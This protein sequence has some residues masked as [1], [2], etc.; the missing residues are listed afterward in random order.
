MDGKT[1]DLQ[2]YKNKGVTLVVT[3]DQVTAPFLIVIND[4]D[5]KKTL[6]YRMY[7]KPKLTLNLPK[8]SSFV[9]LVNDGT[10]KIKDVLIS[11][12]KKIQLKYNFN[13]DLVVPRNYSLNEVKTVYY[14]QIID[15]VNGEPKVLNTPARFIPSLKEKQVS[16]EQMQHFAQ[17]D[18]EFVLDHEEGHYFYGRPYLPDDVIRLLPIS[19]LD[20]SKMSNHFQKQIQEDELEADRYALYKFLNAGYSFSGAFNSLDKNLGDDHFSTQ[21]VLNIN[22]LYKDISKQ[23]KLN[24]L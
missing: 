14:P 17:P 1:I 23:Y 19:T 5:T 8:H 22:S 12:I 18:E 6:Y 7:D 16:I 13:K 21:R 9:T 10:A 20:K 4:T 24:E 2:R 15:Y 11:P 3:F